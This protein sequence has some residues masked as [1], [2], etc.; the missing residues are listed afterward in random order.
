M[1]KTITSVLLLLL[2]GIAYGACTSTGCTDVRVTRL[3]V[4]TQYVTY[5]LTDGDETALNCTLV[6]GVYMTLD[7]YDANYKSVY[8]TLLAAQIADRP[9][10]IRT[11]DNSTN[12]KITYVLLDS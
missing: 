7:H 10:S 4:N 8:S 5:V 11:V 1:A 12:C 2:G 3:Y 6:S 9:V